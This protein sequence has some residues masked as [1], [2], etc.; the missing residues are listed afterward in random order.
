MDVDGLFEVLPE[1]RRRDGSGIELADDSFR[2]LVLPSDPIRARPGTFPRRRIRVDPVGGQ[3][4]IFALPHPLEQLEQGPGNVRDVLDELRLAI[5]LVPQRVPFQQMDTELLAALLKGTLD[6]HRDGGDIV[7]DVFLP[8]ALVGNFGRHDGY[9]DPDPVF[10]LIDLVGAP[11][12]LGGRHARADIGAGLEQQRYSVGKPDNIDALLGD[13]FLIATQTDGRLD[14]EGVSV[15]CRWLV[16]Y[17]G[18]ELGFQDL[19]DSQIEVVFPQGTEAGP[20]RGPEHLDRTEDLD[21]FRQL[22]AVQIGWLGVHAVVV[23]S[24]FL[25]DANGQG[26]GH[27]G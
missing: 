20:I 5:S 25:H 23:E 8:G 7:P 4:I 17:R 16:S 18:H 27:T 24:A 21:E 3:Q 19:A 11:V 1:D 12:D 14:N 15:V 13:G 22:P 6:A 2:V 26:L 10:L 9:E